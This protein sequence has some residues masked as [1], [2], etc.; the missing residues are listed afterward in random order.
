MLDALA[1][2]RRAAVGQIRPERQ[3]AGLRGRLHP[4]SLALL[5]LVLTALAVLAGAAALA[6]RLAG[7]D[8]PPAIAP[9]EDP[10]L[11]TDRL[12]L[13]TAGRRIFSAAWD[14]PG[15]RLHLLQEGGRTQHWQGGPR[16]WSTDRLPAPMRVEGTALAV[17][18]G[19]DPMLPPALTCPLPHRLWALDPDGALA[20]RDGG[21]WHWLSGM[22]RLDFGS[23]GARLSDVQAM[24]MT[25]DGAY[26][27]V[28]GGSS[29]IGLYDTARHSWL[30]VRLP[31]GSTPS[32]AVAPAPPQL[33]LWRGAFWWGS[34]I[35]LHR[36]EPSTGEAQRRVDGAVRALARAH[37]DSA[38]FAAAAAPCAED[39]PDPSL[40]PGPTPAAPL[41][42]RPCPALLRID[43]GSEAQPLWVQQ[44]SRS[45]IQQADLLDVVALGRRLLFVTRLGVLER[46]GGTAHL[47]VDEPIAFSQ[48]LSKDR[49]ALVAGGRMT[50]RTATG[51]EPQQ[52][53]LP[54]DVG[55]L[56]HLAE[57]P[58][59]S[60]LGLSGS[61]NLLALLADG[62][63]QVTPPPR[64]TGFDPADTRRSVVNGDSVALISSDGILT[65]DVATRAYELVR[66]DPVPSWLLDPET[67][68]VLSPQRDRLFVLRPGRSTMTVLRIP[69]GDL[70]EE[71]LHALRGL[72]LPTRPRATED[73]FTVV[74]ARSTV[75][76]VDL[77]AYWRAEYGGYGRGAQAG[78]QI[79][80]MV[81]VLAPP[82]AGSDGGPGTWLHLFS[83]GASMAAVQANG[84]VIGLDPFN[85]AGQATGERVLAP[86]DI[87]GLTSNGSRILA[88]TTDGQLRLAGG[89][90]AFS[91]GPLPPDLRLDALDQAMV[92]PGPNTPDSRVLAMRGGDLVTVYD[93]T[94]RRQLPI[95]AEGALLLGALD[96]QPVY[97]SRY[98]IF[99]GQT[100]MAQLSPGATLVKG[101]AHEAGGTAALL[102]EGE[103]RWLLAGA[104]PAESRIALACA[105]SSL[106]PVGMEAVDEI[107]QDGQSIYVRTL[108]GGYF[109][110]SATTHS[111]SGA[112]GGACHNPQP[113]ASLPEGVED[114]L[115][116]RSPGR[117]RA[118]LSTLWPQAR[119]LS[120]EDY[121]LQVVPGGLAFPGD[122]VRDIAIDSDGFTVLT[123]HTLWYLQNGAATVLQKTFA[124]SANA[125]E[126]MAID[127]NA[128]G[129]RTPKIAMTDA[130][131]VLPPPPATDSLG[132]PPLESARLP[133]PLVPVRVAET[134]GRLGFTVADSTGTAA[135]RQSADGRLGWDV[136]SAVLWSG[137]TVYIATEAGIFA[138]PQQALRGDGSRATLAVAGTVTRLGNAGL[139]EG[140]PPARRLFHGW[141]GSTVY[142]DNGERCL[143]VSAPAP[144][145]DPAA[146]AALRGQ[147]PLPEPSRLCPPGASS[148]EVVSLHDEFW[149][150]RRDS[151]GISGEYLQPGGAP[152]GLA[153]TWSNGRFRHQQVLD[154]IQCR[155]MTVA[156]M[157]GGVMVRGESAGVLPLAEAQDSR[158]LCGNRA[159]MGPDRPAFLAY[160]QRAD[161]SLLG[162]AP[163][164]HPLA[165]QLVPLAPGA[166][167]AQLLEA[168]LQPNA[169]LQRRNLRLSLEPDGTGLRYEL[170][171]A[172]DRWVEQQWL[173]G[174]LRID[175][176]QGIVGIADTAWGITPS[177][178]TPLA[179]V[180][181]LNRIALS[182]RGNTLLTFLPDG[183]SCTLGH[184]DVDGVRLRLYCR[185]ESDTVWSGSLTDA[186][187]GIPAR[188][189]PLDG[190]LAHEPLLPASAA[191]MTPP[192]ADAAAAEAKLPPPAWQ[193]WSAERHR[194]ADGSVASTPLRWQGVP[195]QLR[196]GR[197]DSDIVTGLASLTDNRLE[198]FAAG[199]WWRM[200]FEAPEG[201]NVSLE[202]RPV[203]LDALQLEGTALGVEPL[204]GEPGAT[205]AV[206]LRATEGW[207]AASADLTRRLPDRDCSRPLGRDALWTWQRDAAGRLDVTRGDADGA[208]RQR[209]MDGGRFLDDIATGLPLPVAGWQGGGDAVL[210]P[211]AGGLRVLSTA[212]EDRDLTG[213]PA[214][215][216]AMIAALEPGSAG[217]VQDGFVTPLEGAP[218]VPNLASLLPRGA[219]P[220][221]LRSASD[222]SWQSLLWD[223]GGRTG[224]SLL[225]VGGRTPLPYAD[226]SMLP[227]GLL[228]AGAPAAMLA[229]TAMGAW[230]VQTASGGTDLPLE[231][232]AVLV[233]PWQGRLLT[234]RERHIDLLDLTQR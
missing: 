142:A 14:Q 174:R 208:R 50:I 143:D 197:F 38:L 20:W 74:D 108:A 140:E 155:G 11:G 214:D 167:E 190:G 189:E 152:T 89:T 146:L 48:R 148:S 57:M 118:N 136:V 107:G 76:T 168:S 149:H 15:Q 127:W 84:A 46:E 173:S 106:L 129:E 184:A 19:D 195:V 7:A 113:M 147:P 78:A 145:P 58:D 10:R 87:A 139:A 71:E 1:Q 215:A 207:L 96:A 223:I 55:R 126:P 156:L 216:A 91:G 22:G 40:A 221:A 68:L 82:P 110:Y 226:R 63:V 177:G 16:L 198:L 37:D 132:R 2:A 200:P 170:R 206:C 137:E 12:Q 160:I 70:E 153:V 219:R 232:A 175:D 141:D 202:R 144:V 100:E 169:V 98:G 211:T 125:F 128:P 3:Q 194:R 165:L 30:R 210:L 119:G 83:H 233:A 176:L 230:T 69:Q 77:R 33:V 187:R 123:P 162:L 188:R 111:W 203:D 92:L 60:F 95:R 183:E 73:G 163:G 80:A 67:A 23:G 5:L 227:A 65:H 181:A 185:G 32:D 213:A 29:G 21:A 88:A 94:T 231:G 229:P 159:L 151:G 81:D 201:S 25:E 43:G 124:A 42:P 109:A 56:T 41:P 112:P 104:K 199:R 186:A 218:A 157:P 116:W 93:L 222:G 209:Q 36:I 18:C 72:A 4:V 51:E 102:R 191:A 225:Y 103:R 79:G 178:L 99:R 135:L 196:E 54:N 166:E 164:R 134:D 220:L 180:S 205:P 97:A 105:F 13:D 171:R 158:L 192:P 234:V 62:S 52:W 47:I 217:L 35:G 114:R 133:Y 45:T 131:V 138:T 172:D 17:G 26:V 86:E 212:L 122:S 75:V 39:L 28:A 161:G 53:S 27:G 228:P 90:E 49:L 182:Q 179:Q 193:G 31:E 34:E 85:V 9:L 66:L 121:R 24:A 130:E 115:Y 154:A 8:R 204:A 61:G 6:V 101:F 117:F 150:W 224:R 120:A 64:A 59:G 44:P